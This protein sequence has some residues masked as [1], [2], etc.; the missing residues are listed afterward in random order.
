MSRT[1]ASI[2]ISKMWDS[3]RRKTLLAGTMLVAFGLVPK[4]SLADEGGVSFCKCGRGKQCRTT[5]QDDRSKQRK[6]KDAIELWEL[7]GAGERRHPTLREHK[8]AE[9]QDRK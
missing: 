1:R 3:G 9:C 8:R 6:K 4:A 7:C 5:I 2:Y